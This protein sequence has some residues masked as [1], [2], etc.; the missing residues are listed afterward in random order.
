M[1]YPDAP[2]APRRKKTPAGDAVGKGSGGIGDFLSSRQ[3]KTLQRQVVRGV[4][5]MLRKRI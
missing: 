4:F 5:S 2:E 1:P 3:G